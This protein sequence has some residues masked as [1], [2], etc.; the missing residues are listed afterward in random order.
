MNV[1]NQLI[2]NNAI[3]RKDI[4][5]NPSS[6]IP[7][8]ID[9][10]VILAESSQVP[11]VVNIKNQYRLQGQDLPSS[12]EEIFYK[13]IFDRRATFSGIVQLVITL[14]KFKELSYLTGIA[15]V[16]ILKF[17]K[18]KFDGLKKMLSIENIFKQYDNPNIILDDNC[19]LEF[20]RMI[21]GEE[22]RLLL[23]LRKIKNSI[24]VENQDDKTTIN[25]LLRDE[26]ACVNTLVMERDKANDILSVHLENLLDNSLVGRFCDKRQKIFGICQEV[27]ELIGVK[28]LL[29]KEKISEREILDIVV[30]QGLIAS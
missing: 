21:K 19:F 16:I 28:E 12:Q 25:P 14:L 10:S 29:H 26:L 7:T 18:E 27:L 17:A 23:L 30:K 1:K 5:L 9:S 13:E 6:G 2:E 15:V 8:K 20:D 22:Y 4:Y 3:V 24:L 11:S